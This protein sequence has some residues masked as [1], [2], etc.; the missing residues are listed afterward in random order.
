MIN[1]AIQHFFSLNLL[2]TR[3]IAIFM[4]SRVEK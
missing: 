1:A 4:W 3:S 2:L